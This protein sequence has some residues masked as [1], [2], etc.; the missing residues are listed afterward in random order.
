MSE[1]ETE[2]SEQTPDEKA[3]KQ[4][5][6]EKAAAVSAGAR[7]AAQRAAKAAAKATK[8]GRTNALDT[9]VQKRAMWLSEWIDNNKR[10]VLIA[11]GVVAALLVVAWVGIALMQNSHA[12]AAKE[13]WK[14]VETATA[15]IRSENAPSFDEANLNDSKDETFTS[16][17]ARAEKAKGLFHQVVASHASTKAAAWAELGEGASLLDLGKS[18]DARAVFQKAMQDAGDN[19]II[20]WRAI[21]GIG[22]SYEQEGKWHDAEQRYHELS[23]AGGGNFK[24]IAEYHLARMYLAQGD[25]NRAKETLKGLVEKIRAVETS[26]G[27]NVQGSTYVQNQ[28][29][30]RLMELDSAALPRRARG[31]MGAPG[32]GAPGGQQQMSQEEIQEL[33][34]QLQAKQKKQGG[35]GAPQG[36]PAPAGSAPAPAGNE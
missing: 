18:A 35:P 13:L 15:R 27:P 23:T 5:A 16:I 6:A 11:L 2:T 31:G 20:I 29:E 32:G 12:A 19:P 24:G 3:D 21:E 17:R 22:F 4:A 34:R 10:T 7:L 14:A 36:G 26:A 33:I 8:R 1:N 28:S 25:T 9:Q 30:I